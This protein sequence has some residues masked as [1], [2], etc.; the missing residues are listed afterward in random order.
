MK[1]LVRVVWC[2]LFFLSVCAAASPANASGK[3]KPAESGKTVEAKKAPREVQII[4]K[5]PASSPAFSRFP[6]ALVNDDPVLMQ[7]LTEILAQSHE[8]KEVGKERAGKLE[9]G[10]IL[11]RIIN[12]RL[13]IQEA[14]NIGLDDQ[15]EYKSF[16]EITERQMLTDMLMNELVKDVKPDPAEVE[17]RFREEVV[18][19]KMKSVLF[20][21]EDDA[22]KMVAALKAGKG[23][24]ELV[25]QLVSAKTAT[26]DE[27]Q[28]LK[29]GK[30]LP[31][32]ATAGAALEI[33]G[34]SPI[35]KVT[36]DKVTKFLIFKLEDKRWPEDPKARQQAEQEALADKKN[37]V[38]EQFRKSL[39]KKYV[40]IHDKMLDRL[41]YESP[42]ADLEKLMADTRVLA[43]VKDGQPITVGDLTDGLSSHFYHGLKKAAEEKTVNRKKREMLFKLINKQ[44]IR[45]EAVQR[46]IDRSDAFKDR[47]RDFQNST[48]FGLF[49]KDVILPDIHV[50]REDLTAYYDDHKGEYIY[51][52]MLKLEG[53]AFANRRD[54]ETALARLKKGDDFNWVRANAEGLMATS[55]EDTSYEGQV[56]MKKSLPEGMRKALGNARTGDF[57]L[58]K[59]PEGHFHVLAVQQAIPPRQMPFENVQDEIK[60]KVFDAEV[61]KALA[62]WSAKLR[63]AADIKI[64]LSGMES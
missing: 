13:I 49:V 19:W 30:L 12:T 28:Y 7:D 22:K 33:G 45:R 8:G 47:L 64:Y 60:Q 56:L 27:G 6:I 1:K 14:M 17:K 35:L 55:D 36:P 39:Y 41:D 32:I 62:D 51:P 20:D 9:Y 26:S 2:F 34:T 59:G 54:A 61:D 10:A 16:L 4:L 50:K 46:G 48:L 43:E 21:K 29:P 25:A 42:K 37:Q 53:L 57:T 40:K 38:L 24:D 15:P 52:E 63:A 18:E 5:V 11:D 31:A 44:L 23:F 58:Y 3:K